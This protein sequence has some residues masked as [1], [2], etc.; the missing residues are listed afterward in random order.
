VC[1][2]EPLENNTRF[3]KVEIAVYKVGNVIV[4]CQVLIRLVRN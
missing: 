3:Q 1:T 2:A 4:N